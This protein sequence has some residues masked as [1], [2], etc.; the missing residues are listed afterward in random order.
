MS[1][2]EP[3]EV[4]LEVAEACRELGGESE[5]AA[6]AL[7]ATK[8]AS[9]PTMDRSANKP[10][11]FDCMGSPLHPRPPLAR[12]EPMHRWGVGPEA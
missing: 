7:P 2:G 4:M 6:A 12:A 5:G 3:R 8:S 1:V 11:R 10:R 9:S